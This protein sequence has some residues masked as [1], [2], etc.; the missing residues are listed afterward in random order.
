ML[1]LVLP[2]RNWPSERVD[3]C[4][5]S[6]AALGSP[7]LNE[8]IV[9]DFGS[10][11][12]IVLS[13]HVPSIATVVRLEAEIWSCGEAINAGV[14]LASNDVIAKAD[15][16]MLISNCSRGE[17]ERMVA[18]AAAGRLGI[19]IAQATDLHEELSV[20]DALKVVLNGGKPKGRLRAKWGQG[21]LVIFS[22]KTWEA[23]GGVDSRFTGWGNEDGDFAERVRRSG[24]TLY[25][26]DNAALQ[27]FHVWHKPSISM[28]G[29]LKLRQQNQKIAHTDKSVL[30]SMSFLYSNFAEIA[31]PQIQKRIAPLVTL[32]IATTERPNHLRMVREAIDSFRG[33]I[34]H[35]FE[36]MVVDNGSSEQAVENLRASLN[37][38]QWA[39]GLIRLESTSRASIPGARNLV[40]ENARGKYICVVDDDDTALPNRLA[41]HLRAFQKDGQIHGSHGGWIDWDET[42]GVIERNSGKQ[43][44]AATLLRG[45]GKITA[46]PACFYRKDVMQTVPYD[47]AFALGSDL[48]LALR[49]ALM[50]FRIEHTGSYVTLR[51][52][53]SSN[54][55]IT[56][57]ANQASNGQTAR[58]RA[59]NTYCWNKDA[60]LR[61]R[62][63]EIDK[64][65]Y[66]R[67]QMSFDTIVSKL[68]DYAGVWQIYIPITAF[69]AQQVAEPIQVAPAEASEEFTEHLQQ[70]L[71]DAHEPT[72]EPLTQ[73]DPSST[74]IK[75]NA[76]MLEAVFGVTPGDFC[77]RNAGLNQPI[78][79][80]SA[81]I[82]SLKKAR[83]I[84]K[85]IEALLGIPVQMSS[86]QQSK[87]DREVP[88]NW[89]DL[90]LQSGERALRS[91][92]FDDLSSLM[93]RLNRVNAQSLMGHALKIV[94]D[95]NEDGQVYSLVSPSIR[96]H[97][98]IQ[99]SQ[100]S[101]ELQTGMTFHQIA[102][103]GEACELTLNSRVH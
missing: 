25:W 5:Q 81:A 77:T 78:Y 23:V 95:F 42:T 58:T 33:Q 32:G 19:G 103:N 61:E 45:T 14:L 38:I 85:E 69:K 46:H 86:V 10:A 71:L 72:E 8:I 91:E 28:N 64:E 7:Y 51:R 60:G 1:T 84:K 39:K 41:D 13:E 82:K 75:M 31:S 17:L 80:R 66:C 59:L 16:D 26:A 76:G 52:Y 24:R 100:F 6:F 53:H 62:A 11:E 43:R 87:I 37:K 4:I 67:N 90:N 44:T 50:G 99:Q 36:I 48:D 98:A 65:V 21:G 68:P 101:L 34:D 57:T 79:F 63:K 92:T 96:G 73:A 97:E 74:I 102:A 15:A 70:N 49:M 29:I 93:A 40:T 2:V 83:K 55:T 56:G 89:K 54:V 27:L 94:A 47:E 12:P 3:A 22:R 88:F 9:V 35:D 30:R 20:Q 18:D